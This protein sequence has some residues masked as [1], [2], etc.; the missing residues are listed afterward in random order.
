MVARGGNHPSTHASNVARLGTGPKTA[1][2]EAAART[3][4][5]ST[6][7]RLPIAMISAGFSRRGDLKVI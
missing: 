1:L 2:R 6:E 5:L 3:W 7:R 4:V